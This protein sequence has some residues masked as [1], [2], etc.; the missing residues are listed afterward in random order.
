MKKV[1]ISI[2]YE[3]EIDID[4][5]NEEFDNNFDKLRSEIKDDS[6]KFVTSNFN[7]ADI[8]IIYELEE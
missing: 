1:K 8:R 3:F 7:K 4:D 2:G 6:I 5:S